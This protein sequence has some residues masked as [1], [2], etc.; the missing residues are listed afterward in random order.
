LKFKK[1]DVSPVITHKLPL[2]D[3]HEGMEAVIS[4]KKEVGKVVFFPEAK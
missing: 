4:A 2:K 3:F 1:V